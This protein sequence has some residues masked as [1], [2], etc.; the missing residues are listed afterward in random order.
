MGDD[1]KRIMLLACSALMLA[2]CSTIRKTATTADVATSINQYPVVAD[3]E[4][5]AKVTETTTW[6]W[7]PFMGDKF[8]VRKG[9]LVAETLRKYDADI[10]LEPQFII[11]KTL[12]GERSITVMGFPVKY[13]SFHKAT[14]SDL[15]AIE[16][17][18][19]YNS[20]QKYNVTKSETVTIVK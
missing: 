10:L 11:T 20:V 17:V 12:F 6:S 7:N 18:N 16:A 3:G 9:N 15:K 5:K 4:V 13:N 1:M 2:S 19:E 14:D 8:K